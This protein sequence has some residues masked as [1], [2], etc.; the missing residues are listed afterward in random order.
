MSL[1][2]KDQYVYSDEKQRSPL[3]PATAWS[4][5]LLLK[6]SWGYRVVTV[7]E[8]KAKYAYG[9]YIYGKYV[10]GRCVYERCVYGRCVNGRRVYGRCI[11]GRYVYG[12]CVY[13]TTVCQLEGG[14][15]CIKEK[16]ERVSMRKVSHGGRGET[17][18]L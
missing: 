6:D 18:C 11:Y 14:G 4:V 3:F 17:Y 7:A 1:Q 16:Q 12:R 5:A 2:K 8:A 13:G 15:G 10:N 9:R